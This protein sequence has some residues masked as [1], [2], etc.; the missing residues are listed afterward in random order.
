[1]S[2][3][4]LPSLT[5]GGDLLSTEKSTAARILE[6]PFIN[7]A[8]H[9]LVQG[10]VDAVTQVIDKTTGS[11]LLPDVRIIP[12][13]R[14]TEFGSGDWLQQQ[15]GAAAGALPYLLLLHKGSRAMLSDRML[16]ADTKLMLDAGVKLGS[17]G[18]RKSEGLNWPAR[19]QQAPRIVVY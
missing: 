14:K 5:K 8:A 17:T 2:D 10:P 12:D 15:A 1:M 13:A 7:S 18:L 11:N 19:A 4:Q 6:N 9:T 16:S 3:S